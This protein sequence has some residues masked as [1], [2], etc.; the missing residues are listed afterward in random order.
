[1]PCSTRQAKPCCKLVFTV[2][3]CARPCRGLKAL[4]SPEAVIK[5]PGEVRCKDECL[6]LQPKAHMKMQPGRATQTTEADSTACHLQIF[7]SNGQ[8]HKAA[9]RPQ[10]H[11]GEAAEQLQA[12]RQ[13]PVAVRKEATST[14]SQTCQSSWPAKPHLKQ[15]ILQ[16]CLAL[17]Q[18]SPLI[19][20]LHSKGRA[21]TCIEVLSQDWSCSIRVLVQLKALLSS[22]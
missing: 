1:M 2:H 18:V 22:S 12:T 4:S 20:V 7:Q 13:H 11:L 14:S 8:Y 15:S 16:S 10:L 6:Q 19:S 21:H 9:G 3:S 5:G 17:Q